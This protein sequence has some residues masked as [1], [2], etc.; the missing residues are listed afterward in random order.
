MAEIWSAGCC[1]KRHCKRARF[2]SAGGTVVLP[3]GSTR[4]VRFLGGR[5]QFLEICRDLFFPTSE[6]G[7]SFFWGALSFSVLWRRLIHDFHFPKL[8]RLRRRQPILQTS[9]CCL[10]RCCRPPTHFQEALSLDQSNRQND[11]ACGLRKAKDP[12]DGAQQF[13]EDRRSFGEETQRSNQFMVCFDKCQ[14][15]GVA[16][17]LQPACSAA[18][19]GTSYGWSDGCATFSHCPLPP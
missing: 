8:P 10:L 13:A 11:L 1:L 15:I 19:G 17:C 12:L 2:V 3:M 6:H 4:A 16:L 5:F 9:L 14:P 7:V 18:R